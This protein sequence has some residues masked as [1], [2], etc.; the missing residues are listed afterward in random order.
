MPEL[1]L[2]RVPS[3]A[4]ASNFSFAPVLALPAGSIIDGFDVSYNPR[5]GVSEH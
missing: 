2:G 1:G 4:L 3:E 5:C